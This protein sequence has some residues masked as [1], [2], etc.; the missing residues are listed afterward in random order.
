MIHLNQQKHK[1]RNLKTE[2]LHERYVNR[3]INDEKDINDQ[4]FSKYPK[5]PNLS[6]SAKIYINSIKLKISKN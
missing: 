2:K 6:V 3:I 5:Y 4:I 1:L